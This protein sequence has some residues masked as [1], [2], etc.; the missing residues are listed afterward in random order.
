M[1]TDTTAPADESMPLPTAWA[2]VDELLALERVA[3]YL[4]PSD[5]WTAQLIRTHA[6]AIGRLLV[7]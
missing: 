7:D 4:A 6:L 1:P 3:H 2:I 5:P